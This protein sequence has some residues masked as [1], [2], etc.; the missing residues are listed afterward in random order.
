[1]LPRCSWKVCMSASNWQGCRS[2]DRPL[3]TGTWLLAAKFFSVAWA[4]VRIITASSMRD[5]TRALSAIG[6]PRPNWVSRGERKI[7]CPPSWIM[8]ASNDKRVRVEAFSK[9]IPSTRFFSGSYS[10][11]RWRRS[12]SSLA[13]RIRLRSSSGV[14]SIRERKWRT[15]LIHHYLTGGLAGVWPSP[16]SARVR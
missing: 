10:T 5:I 16:D 11:P 2:S 9:I 13:R 4:K 7:A 15:V 1:M 14:M 6:S 3:I 12:F 8:P